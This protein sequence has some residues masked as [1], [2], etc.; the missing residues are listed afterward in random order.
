MRVS[1][2]MKSKIF[3]I[4]LFALFA[5]LSAADYE[6]LIFTRAYQDS[7]GKHVAF[8]RK[9]LASAIVRFQ[10]EIN[11]FPDIPIEI[12]IAPNKQTYTHW[13]AGR[14]IVFDSSL[15]FVDLEQTRVYVKH[16]SQIGSNKKLI[17][18]L[19]H[20]YIHIF[21]HHH[22]A[23]A[24][25]WFHEGMAMY[26]THEVN[27]GFL[28]YVLSNNSIHS[29]YLLP[30]HQY[31]YPEHKA[32]IEP[33]YFQS[34]LVVRKLVELHREQFIRLFAFAEEEIDFETSFLLAMGKSVDSFLLDSEK[35]LKDIYK[36][37][38]YKAIIMLSWL[39]FPIIL[40]IAKI[41]KNH[42][43]KKLLEQWEIEEQIEEQNESI[44]E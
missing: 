16:P 44:G 1:S 2:E 42:K 4:V 41:K 10:R 8:I 29:R 34:A 17:Q 27:F 18:V 43:T 19:L 30:K 12:H 38:V 33:Y 36:L 28:E 7:D 5:V 24:P 23:D 22:W 13:T 35:A 39:S 40:I 11:S 37:N 6:N 9:E 3:F 31:T 26:F 25:L 21:I 15:A 32:E 20:E 14:H